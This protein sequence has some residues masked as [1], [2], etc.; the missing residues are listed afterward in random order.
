LFQA[1]WVMSKIRSRVF[2]AAI[3]LGFH[4]RAAAQGQDPD[5]PSRDKIRLQYRG[6]LECPD[7][8]T[9]EALVG[10][11]VPEG[12]E[13]A[14]EE[15]ARR[16]DVA[17]SG[18]PGGYVATIEFVDEGGERVARAVRGAQCSEVVDGIAFVTALAIQ[19]RVSEALDRSEPVTMPDSSPAN[20]PAP[21]PPPIPIVRADPAPKPEAPPP[22]PAPANERSPLGFRVSARAALATGT[23]PEVSPGAALG[24]VYEWGYS[25]LGVAFQ[26]FRGGRVES[27]GVEARFERYSVRVEG[28]PFAFVLADWASFEPCPFV[29]LGSIT[30][31]AFE[32]P[33][34]VASGYPDSAFWLSTGAFGRAVGRF[35]AVAVE[36]EALVGVPFRRERFYVEGG[37]VVYRVPAVYGA[38]A[39]GL[40]VRF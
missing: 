23:G 19:S 35:G 2:G 9:F 1:D 6:P 32:D 39:V 8:E 33:P 38:V 16:I 21:A 11:R 29:D 17:V 40:G 4:P 37:E 28:C 20:V 18:A 30:G 12:W 25:R 14:P 15:L 10:S 24:I 34:E 31:E 36:L 5:A 3:V 22:R 26:G 7:A 13:A 27:Q